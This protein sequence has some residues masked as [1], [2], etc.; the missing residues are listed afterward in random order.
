M[1][2]LLKILILIVIIGFL[3]WGLFNLERQTV[4]LETK[5]NN[6]KT[7]A[8][9]IEKENKIINENIEYFKHPENL[10]KELKSLFNYHEPGEKM[11][12]I[13]Q[14]NNENR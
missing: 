4:R 12:I 14:K 2:R 13:P 10:L 1:M 11:I 3:A 6:L 7:D 9:A 8:E 5:Y